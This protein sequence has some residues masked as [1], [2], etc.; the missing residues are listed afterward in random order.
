MTTSVASSPLAGLVAADVM[1][2]GLL[3]CE[4][5][6][7]RSELASL[8][9]VNEVHAVALADA[10]GVVTA[11]DLVA[12]PRHAVAAELASSPATVGPSDGLSAAAAL[13]ARERRSHVVVVG[14]S[15]T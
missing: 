12:A 6:T 15:S 7:P 3:T 9:A 14:R 13:M 2:P 11:L 1:S 4:R 5:E 8:M 10:S